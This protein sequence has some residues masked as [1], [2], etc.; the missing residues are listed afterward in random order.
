MQERLK[1]LRTSFGMSQE[2]FAKR[3]GFSTR[4]AVNNW[5]VGRGYP[6]AEM[7]DLI[8]ERFKVSKEWLET[9]N[10][11]MFDESHPSSDEQ[12]ADFIGDVLSGEMDIRYRL[13]SVLSKLDPEDWKLLEK[14]LQK[15]KET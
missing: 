11:N 15:L 12:I 10:G 13:I 8:C 4:G 9:G 7:I 5:E 14:V 2:Q 1:A 6:S 3:L